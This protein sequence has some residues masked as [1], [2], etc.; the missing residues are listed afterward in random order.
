[1][2][3]AEI[4]KSSRLWSLSLSLSTE[5]SQLGYIN[6]YRGVDTENLL[7]DINYL[8][9]FFQHQMAFAVERIIDG[10]K[11]QAGLKELK[12]LKVAVAAPTLLKAG[13]F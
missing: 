2:G 13:G 10:D 4:L 1:M 9:N 5:Q 7:L 3:A 12:E 8:C 6:L 11:Q